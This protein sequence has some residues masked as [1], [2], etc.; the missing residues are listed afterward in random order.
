MTIMRTADEIE[1]RALKVM[2]GI[3][4]FGLEDLV[5]CLPAD[6]AKQFLK[7]GADISEWQAM[8]VDADSIKARMLDYM[9]FAWDKANNRR[10]LS[11]W[12]SLA[13][14]QSWLWL[15]G[16]DAV[17]DALDDYDRYGKPHLRAI[18]E[19]FGWSWR[20]WDDGM[21]TNDETADG[22]APPETVATLPFRGNI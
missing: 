3:L 11:A 20:E 8:A 10:G 12:R 21:W 22:T 6:R 16:E 15:L 7:E 5:V 19:H 1:A 14:M 2:D 13:H 18:C 4:A 9:P 17:A